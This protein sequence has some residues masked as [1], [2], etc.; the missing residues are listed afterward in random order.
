MAKES[1]SV[2]ADD[3]SVCVCDREMMD[4]WKESAEKRR[5][6]LSIACGRLLRA[7]QAEIRDRAWVLEEN[8]EGL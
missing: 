3:G 8:S 1:A 2:T 6:V 5:A 4:W 7:F